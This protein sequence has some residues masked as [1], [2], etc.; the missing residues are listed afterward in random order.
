MLKVGGKVRAI[1]VCAMEDYDVVPGDVEALTLGKEYE[2][3][4]VHSFTLQPHCSYFEIVSEV[5]DRHM[6][7][8]DEVT[9][10]E[11]GEVLQDWHYFEIVKE[12]NTNGN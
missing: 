4:F 12:S 10:L 3:M 2:V 5:G 1:D 6:F 8:F 9:M 11:E 7:N